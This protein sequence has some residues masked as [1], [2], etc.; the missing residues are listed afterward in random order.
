[1]ATMRGR[2]GWGVMAFLAVNVAGYAAAVLLVPAIRGP[3]LMDMLARTRAGTYAHVAGGALAISIGAWQANARLRARHPEAHRRLGLVYLA[4]VVTGGVAGFVLAFGSAGGEV[5]HLGFG[6]LAV[7]WLGCTVRGYAAYR[8][9][10]YVAHGRWM[11]RSYAL[12]LAAVTL[13][14]YL[15]LA[16]AAGVPFLP[17]YRAISWLCW[18]PNLLAAELLL[19]RP[20]PA[21]AIAA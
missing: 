1:M 3:V 11:I 15:P 20:R 4:T 2:L 19:R 18:V 9:S 6:L 10:D 13:R 8:A 21:P 17:A 7:S 14:L 5:T 16:L 12:T